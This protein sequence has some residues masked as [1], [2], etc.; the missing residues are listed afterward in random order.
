M[1][2]YSKCG[3]TCNAHVL[4]TIALADPH[5]IAPESMTE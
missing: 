5:N 4:E 3:T 2:N 1:K